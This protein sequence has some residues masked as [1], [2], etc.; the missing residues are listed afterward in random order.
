M[1]CF[2]ATPQER[3]LAFQFRSA[4]ERYRLID[5]V[6]VQVLVVYDATSRNLRDRMLLGDA[7]GFIDYRLAQRYLVGVYEQVKFALWKSGAIEEHKAGSGLW[8]LV[9]ERVYNEEKGLSLSDA[10][11]TAEECVV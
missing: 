11:Y 3:E 8:L 4:A 1:A 2:R 9:N 7:G 10:R 6:Q 5:D